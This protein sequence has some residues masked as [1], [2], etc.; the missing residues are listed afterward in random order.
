MNEILDFWYG[1]LPTQFDKAS[2]A[3]Q[4]CWYKKDPAFDEE[5]RTKFGDLVEDAL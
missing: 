1:E 2:E 5:I 3:K 4:A